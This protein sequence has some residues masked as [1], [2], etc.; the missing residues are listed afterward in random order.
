MNLS[1]SFL[2]DSALFEDKAWLAES[3]AQGLWDGGD[4]DQNTN[5][6]LWWIGIE[7]GATGGPPLGSKTQEK[8]IRIHGG[9][10]V[11]FTN[12]GDTVPC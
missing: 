3:H 4:G 9:K 2:C 12:L 5:G 10:S 8:S 1:C 11:Y 7:D 6:T